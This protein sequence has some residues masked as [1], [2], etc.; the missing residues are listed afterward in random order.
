MLDFLCLCNI[1]NMKNS[2]V[3]IITNKKNGTLYIGATTNLA[4]R[5]YQHKN[6]FLDPGYF[7]ASSA[8]RPGNPRLLAIANSLWKAIDTQL[9][10]FTIATLDGMTYFELLSNYQSLKLIIVY[11]NYCHHS[12]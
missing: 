8:A 7:A 10:L 1:L 11:F 12:G 9:L 2:Y 5:I 3:Y 6:S 4:Q